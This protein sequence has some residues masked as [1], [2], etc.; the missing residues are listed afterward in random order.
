MHP[1]PCIG[2]ARALRGLRSQSAHRRTLAG[3]Y[4]LSARAQGSAR[5]SLVD[6]SDLHPRVH[7][8]AAP[9]GVSAPQLAHRCHTPAGWGA[10][11]QR[12]SRCQSPA[13]S[14]C[15]P[16]SRQHASR[17]YRPSSRRTTGPQDGIVTRECPASLG[18]LM[19]RSPLTPV[20]SR[21]ARRQDNATWR[22]RPW[23]T[24]KGTRRWHSQG[25]RCILDEPTPRETQAHLRSAWVVGQFSGR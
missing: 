8:R 6:Y 11:S 19:G 7:G 21:G 18:I 14:A 9:W 3:L 24:L 15:A 5:G 2:P 22:P 23:G 25:C 16:I 13:Q 20:R 12:F 4:Q 17:W 1:P 10:V